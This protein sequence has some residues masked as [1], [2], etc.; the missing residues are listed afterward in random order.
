MLLDV[1]CLLI[2]FLK[3]LIFR[4]WQWAQCDQMARIFFIQPF[5]QWKFLPVANQ[6]DKVRSNVLPNDNLSFLKGPNYFSNFAKLSK[7]RKIWSHWIL[8]MLKKF[9]NERKV[10]RKKLFYFFFRRQRRRRRRRQ[11]QNTFERNFMFLL[12]STLMLLTSTSL[13]LALKV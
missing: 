1:S 8:Q 2:L 7:F 5:I 12:L 3:I 13:S 10:L 11:N 9:S 6:F 4:C